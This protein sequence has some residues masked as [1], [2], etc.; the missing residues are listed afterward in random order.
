MLL[1]GWTMRYAV[2]VLLLALVSGYSLQNACAGELNSGSAASPAETGSSS[3]DS[4]ARLKVKAEDES[5][6]GWLDGVFPSMSNCTPHKFYYDVYKKRSENGILESNGYHPYKVDA[7]IASY[8][9]HEKFF[10]LDATEIIVPAGTISSYGVIVSSS[11]KHLSEAIRN[12]TGH[13]V[14]IAGPKFKVQSGK[15]FIM[16]RGTNQSLFVCTTY[17]GGDE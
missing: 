14:T 12:V 11:A 1:K 4:P 2:F 8:K 13:M 17:Y 7:E 9:I 10:G 5:R 15:A 6:S 16:S 3:A